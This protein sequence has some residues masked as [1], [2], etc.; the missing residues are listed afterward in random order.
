MRTL[1]LDFEVQTLLQEASRNHG[2]YGG[3]LLLWLNMF[4]TPTPRPLSNASNAVLLQASETASG[5]TPPSAKDSAKKSKKVSKLAGGRADVGMMVAKDFPPQGVF[6]GT[7]LS[8]AKG[9]SPLWKIRL[10][11]FPSLFR[12]WCVR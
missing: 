1:F 10:V 11:V 12:I 5:A 4:N 6:T 8:V 3:S 7:V 9:K 2:V